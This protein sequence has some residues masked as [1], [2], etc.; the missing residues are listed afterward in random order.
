VLRLH[1]LDDEWV[2]MALGDTAVP[3]ALCQLKISHGLAWDR[4]LASSVHLEAV[5]VTCVTWVTGLRGR[6]W[7]GDSS[8]MYAGRH[9]S[10]HKARGW[11][12][13]VWIAGYNAK[14]AGYNAK[15][16]RSTCCFISNVLTNWCRY[17]QYVNGRLSGLVTFCVEAAFYDRLLKER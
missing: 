1:S 3:M 14:I 13:C 8:V 7:G 11:V 5:W 4:T 17:Y 12:S 10:G 9:R 6:V 15:I 16:A 2:N